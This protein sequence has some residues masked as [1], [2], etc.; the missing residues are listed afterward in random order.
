MVD[1]RKINVGKYNM[2]VRLFNQGDGKDVVVLI[3]GIP[4]NSHLWDYVIPYLKQNYTVLA[5]DMIGYGKSDRGP[6]EDLTL[7]KQSQYILT[8]M[9]QLQI[10]KAHFIGH[11]LGGG[12]VQI[13]AVHHPERMKSMIVIDGVTYANWPLP[14]VESIRYPTAEE[15]MPSPLFIE[16]MLREG[17]YFPSMLTPG[18]LQKFTSP[19]NTPSGPEELRQ[20]SLALNHHQTEDLVPYLPNISKPVTLLWG[21]HDRFLVP[22]WGMILHQTIPGSVF[23]IIPNAS[24]YSMIDQPTL[25][26]AAFLEHLDA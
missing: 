1:E 5:V 9:D 16:R 17:V 14:I 6:C 13:I 2:N 4:T 12:V 25:A 26:A 22:Y 8:A 18:L 23:K 3:H 10:E 21:Q 15:F 24:H 19:F 7:P 20:A 11:D